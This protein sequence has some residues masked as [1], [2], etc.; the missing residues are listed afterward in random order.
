MKAKRPHFDLKLT[1]QKAGLVC[2]TAVE[3]TPHDQGV[4][5]LIST[6]QWAFILLLQTF[7]IVFQQLSAPKLVDKGRKSSRRPNRDW[8]LN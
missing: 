4:V 2:N 7:P 5:G 6:C 1:L 3:Q 8:R